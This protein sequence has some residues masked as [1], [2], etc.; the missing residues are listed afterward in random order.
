MGVQT[1]IEKNKKRVYY[2]D[3]GISDEE[4]EKKQDPN[5]DCYNDDIFFL[6][7]RKKFTINERHFIFKLYSRNNTLF[8]CPCCKLN[9]LSFYECRGWEISHKISLKNG[10]SNLYDNLIPLCLSC[11]SGM[12]TYSYDEYKNFFDVNVNWFK[13][14][15]LNIPKGIKGI[16]I[17]KHKHLCIICNKNS[18]YL[19][20]IPHPYKN[21]PTGYLPTIQNMICICNIC[22]QKSPTIIIKNN[23]TIHNKNNKHNYLATRFMIVIF[24]IIIFYVKFIFT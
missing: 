9:N 6:Q 8:A 7:K 15:T 17:K 13:Y 23:N 21:I 19:D 14:P 5:Y 11:N 1:R 3:D 22:N 20:V 18:F 2:Q 12:T 10:G 24:V 4:T 16:I